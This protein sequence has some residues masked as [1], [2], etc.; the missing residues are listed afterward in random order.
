MG[1]LRALQMDIIPKITHPK[2]NS[3]KAAEQAFVKSFEDLI[4]EKNFLTSAI[5][6]LQIRKTKLEEILHSLEKEK[7]KLNF[8]NKALIGGME[9]TKQDVAE[10]ERESQSKIKRDGEAFTQEKETEQKRLT[11]LLDTLEAKEDQLTVLEDKLSKLDKQLAGQETNIAGRETSL[12]KE[13]ESISGKE[14]VLNK[15][16]EGVS[17][18]EGN[19]KGREEGILD[20]EKG[21][22]E[23]EKDLRD[24]LSAFKEVF[25][26]KT[27]QIE[28]LTTQL[29]KREEQYKL[30][31]KGLRE[32]EGN[33]KKR[34]ILLHD[35]ETIFKMNSPK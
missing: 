12:S 25:T 4:D 27:A 5:Q 11:D 15:K 20:K 35:R 6:D 13:Q 10:K 1:Y 2:L 7:D 30:K 34:E 21:L 19:L 18:V 26:N 17:V 9:T 24:K 8:D 33:L 31:F 14:E 3:F 22:S 16:I 32:I 28:Q 29:E 23:Q